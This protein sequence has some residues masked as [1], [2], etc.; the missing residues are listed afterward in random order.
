MSQQRPRIIIAQ[1]QRLAL[2]A[3]LQASIRL[4]RSDTA[5]LTRY[6]EEQ[7]AENPHLRLVPPEPAGFGDWLPRWSGVMSFGAHENASAPEPAS[8]QPSLIAHVT[9]AIRA[10][11][12]DAKAQRIA[13]ALVEALEPS[14]WLGRKPDTVARELAC[15]QSDVEVVLSKLQRID[16]PGLF[17]KD[18]ADCLAL[19]AR[20]QGVLDAEMTVILQN[21]N[22]LAASELSKLAKLCGCDDAGI[23]TRFRLIRAMNPKPGAAFSGPDPVLTREPDLIVRPVKGGQWEVILNRSALPSLAI[24]TTPSRASAD[25]KA[26]SN[27]KSLK[28]MLQA[29]NDT[30]LRVGRE[31]ATRQIAALQVGRLALLPMTMADVAEAVG[32]HISTI[33]R[34]VAGA[35]M[36]SP[37]GTWWLRR[38]FS[39]ARG[40]GEGDSQPQVSAASLRQKICEIISLEDSAKP[41]T[42]QSLATALTAETGVTLARRTVAQYREAEGIPSTPYRRRRPIKR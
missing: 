15:A 2:N 8:A 18:L 32:L 12:L 1:Q 23:V 11:N 31:I 28:H 33:S 36:D 42:D 16:P 29:R 41:M 10:M 4:L 9:D 21:L 24:E 13:L 27:A 26:L 34:V 3:S 40:T 38:M 22:L 35:S 17:A 39:G 37:K 30:L 20:D 25:P 14:G 19:Q 6:L 7:A 5:G